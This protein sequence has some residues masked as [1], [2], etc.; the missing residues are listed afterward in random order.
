MDGLTNGGKF[1][2]LTVAQ[3][4]EL[5]ECLVDEAMPR[6]DLACTAVPSD[7]SDPRNATDDVSPG[8]APQVQGEGWRARCGRSDMSDQWIIVVGSLGALDKIVGPFDQFWRAVEV[9]A[10]QEVESSRLSTRRADVAR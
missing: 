6:T 9:I 7:G 2:P 8:T 1:S 5:C 10:R 3:I 4:D